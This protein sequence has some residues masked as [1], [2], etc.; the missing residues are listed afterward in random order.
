MDT[1]LLQTQIFSDFIIVYN[2]FI[3]EQDCS[4]GFCQAQAMV[5][6]KAMLLGFYCRL[7]NHDA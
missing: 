4:K 2:G 6:Y 5:L 7:Q 3:H 1:G